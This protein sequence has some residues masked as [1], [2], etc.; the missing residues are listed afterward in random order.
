MQKI[1]VDLRV[2]RDWAMRYPMT[3]AFCLSFVVHLA[4]FGGW[5]MGDR[6]GWWKH[7]ATWL[8]DITK[9]KATPSRLAKLLQPKQMQVAARQ[10]IPLTFVEVDPST[11][12]KEA[13]K[14]AKYYAVKN[15]VASNIDPLQETTIPKIDGTQDKVVRTDNVP[16]PG[17][18][19]LQPSLSPEPKSDSEQ[20]PK[21]EIPGDTLFKRSNPDVMAFKQDRPR[22]LREIREQNGNIAGAKVRQDGGVQR[23]GRIS[24]DAVESPFGAYDAY[25]IAAIQQRWYDLLDNAHF[26]Q[27]I[28]K[29]V[30]EFK[31][32]YDGRIT[33]VKMNDN[34]VGEL[35]AALCQRA[36]TDPS[37]FAK[38]PDDM[39]RLVGKNFREVL[40]TFYYE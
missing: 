23:R 20:Q 29:V 17:P 35:L 39:R 28:G 27:R 21:K 10:E 26:S 2:L 19:P 12:V 32:N 6:L 22:T 40:F 14:N 34:E 11:A 1:A 7:Q 9:K 13:P 36:I 4:L 15:S 33:D 5:K 8:L 37:P 3:T 38:W 24:L 31:L 16:K 18:Q 25:I 30:I